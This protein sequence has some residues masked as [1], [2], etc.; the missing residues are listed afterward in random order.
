MSKNILLFSVSFGEGHNQAAHALSQEFLRQ[1]PKNNVKVVN[2]LDYVN[3]M[4]DKMFKNVYLSSL[5]INPKVWG[6]IY[7]QTSSTTHSS[8]LNETLTM[9]STIKIKRLFREFKPDLLICTHAFAAGILS[10][11]KDKAV[12]DSRIPLACIITDFDCHSY[13]VNPNVDLY[14]AADKMMRFDCLKK[15]IS[16]RKL[17]F[18]GIPIRADFAKEYETKVLKEEFGL[19][20]RPVVLIM[21]GGKGMGNLQEVTEIILQNNKHCQVL[22]VAGQNKPL[23]ERLSELKEKHSN[24]KVFGF[25]PNIPQLMAVSDFVITKPGGLTVSEA[26]AMRLP[27]IIIDPLPGQEIKNTSFLINMGV[28]IYV[29]Q[30]KEL[31]LIIDQI[32]HCPL[33]LQHMKEMAALIGKKDAAKR[34]CT[35]L[36]KQ[37]TNS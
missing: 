8:F 14:F 2:T 7:D 28:A 17:H 30:I 29:N 13:W 37:K 1:D 22:A 23:F 4:F 20:D 6:T 25:V 26:L 3:S 18:Y 5:K 36:L 21:G 19:D 10:L 11:L 16:R 15:G 12:I 9:L 27:I 31:N 32:T 35:Y 33:R 24:L 34:I